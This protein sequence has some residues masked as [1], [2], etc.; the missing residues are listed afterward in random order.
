MRG[1]G[2]KFHDNTGTVLPGNLF[3]TTYFLLGLQRRRSPSLVWTSRSP[4]EWG[5]IY[6]MLSGAASNE[7]SH[8]ESGSGN[9]AWE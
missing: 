5:F 3:L 2:G 4:S 1:S 7:N 9:T 6:S 8:G